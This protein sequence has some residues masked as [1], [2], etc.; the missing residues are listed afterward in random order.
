MLCQ[1]P[2][3]HGTSSC[4]PAPSESLSNC[5]AI[6]SSQWEHTGLESKK[7]PPSVEPQEEQPRLSLC[8]KPLPVSFTSTQW[9]AITAPFL[10][11]SSFCSISQCFKRCATNPLLKAHCLSCLDWLLLSSANNLSINLLLFFCPLTFL[12]ILFVCLFVS[13]TCLTPC[14]SH[15]ASI[16]LPKGNFYFP[17][18]KLTFQFISL[19]A[20]DKI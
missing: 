13:F 2:V 17:C 18:P 1:Y 16:F 20:S 7:E 14:Q 19:R 10:T 3:L 5:P 12:K 15:W 4:K 6:R 8:K 9:F 11:S